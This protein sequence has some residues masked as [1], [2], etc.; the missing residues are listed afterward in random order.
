MGALLKPRHRLTSIDSEA[1]FHQDDD[2][3]VPG[4][5]NVV[6]IELGAFKLRVALDDVRCIGASVVAIVSSACPRTPTV[7][8]KRKTTRPSCS[9]ELPRSVPWI[10]NREKVRL[11]V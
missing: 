5:Q 3:R 11:R 9:N 8:P 1:R 6:K 2:I 10:W 7:S 4:R